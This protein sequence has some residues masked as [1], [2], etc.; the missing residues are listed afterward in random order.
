PQLIIVI[1]ALVAS[2][3]PAAVSWLYFANRLIE[4]P[5]GIVGV[6]MGAVLVPELS[7][8]VR[9]D[10]TAAHTRAAAHAL[11]L[12]IGVALPA[13]L[14]LIVLREPIVRLLFEHGAFSPEDAAATAQALALLALGLPAQVLAKNA[15]AS[16]FAR[17]DTSTPLVATLA[18]LI[19]V[20]IAA[21][22]LGWLFGV[23]GVAAAVAL[24]AWTNAGLLLGRSD[25]PFLEPA[26]RSRLV[27]IVLAAAI[28]G[29]LL[30]LKTSLVL[31]LAAQAPTLVQAGLLGVLIAGGLIIYAA[32]LLLLGIVSLRTAR[33]ALRRPGLR[34]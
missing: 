18:S 15:A 24:G 20:L 17:E 33:D 8:A 32:A 26:S 5:L 28:M 22:G 12:A 21:V 23:G 11:E 16:L 2:G 7:R 3:Q 14:G 25:R 1:A 29:G 30:W 19:V 10:D 6:A 9:S 13:T 34:D 27:R 31:P 4:L